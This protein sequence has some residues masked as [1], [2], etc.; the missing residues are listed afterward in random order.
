MLFY[1][2]A[3]VFILSALLLLFTACGNREKTRSVKHSSQPILRIAMDTPIEGYDPAKVRSLSSSTIM[4]M[5]YEGLVRKSPDGNLVPGIAYKWEI[6]P[7]GKT[8]T[9][10]LRKALWNNNDPVVAED[11]VWAWKR[12]LNPKFPAPNAFQF[13]PIEGAKEAKTKEASLQKVQ[14]TALDEQTL[15]V[16]LKEPTAHFLESLTFHAFFPLPSYYCQDNPQWDTGPL[17]EI[18]VNGPFTT[19]EQGI[20]TKNNL[21]WDQEQ[22]HIEKIQLYQEDS[23]TS[24]MLFESAGVDIAGSPLDTLPADALE[25]LKEQGLLRIAPAA[26]TQF[27]RFNTKDATFSDARVRRALAFA[28]DRDSICDHI[29]QAGQSPATSLVP[30]YISHTSPS[31]GSL[32]VD[33][34]RTAARSQLAATDAARAEF[35]L[36]YPSGN[37]R[38]HK[39]AQVL[40]QQWKQALGIHVKLERMES[41]VV[42]DR[43]AQGDYQMS[44]GSWFADIDDPIN[45]LEV[46]E[47]ADNGTNNTGWESKRFQKILAKSRREQDLSKR[48]LYLQ[49]AEA[50]LIEQMPICPI[51]TFT[52]AYLM[53]DNITGLYLSPLGF[54]DFKYAKKI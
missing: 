5:M 38:Y 18:V 20:F 42:Y 24:V 12:Q 47:N 31:A 10:Y 23:N 35:V 48:A 26:G 22:V 45:F 1:K 11:F 2:K 50:L 8:Y 37:E 46:F 13:Y 7:D 41:K 39:L 21:Y 44:I 53:A 33:A 4:R 54:L 40:Q 34:S 28:L 17:Q 36:T 52:F 32:F 9:F 29:L 43:I 25:P 15:Q 6:S 51:N 14:I 16:Q 27:L 49:E 19:E 3:S 30:P